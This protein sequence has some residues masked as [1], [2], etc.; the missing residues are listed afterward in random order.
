MPDQLRADIFLE[1]LAEA[2]KSG[3]WPDFVTII[4]PNDHTCGLNPGY[5]TPR[6]Y[7]SDN[8]LALGRI[9]EGISKS[10]FWPTTVIFV[11]EDDPQSGYDHV[12][13]HRSLCLVASPYAKHGA[14]VSRFYNQTS[15]LHTIELILGLPPMNQL[16]AA[17][18][19]MEDCFQATPDPSPYKCLVPEFPSD[20][21]NG[22]RAV[23]MWRRKDA[24]PVHR[25]LRLFQ[26]D[27]IDE[28]ALNRAAW[29][30]KRRASATRPSTRP[31]RQ[32][33]EAVG[34]H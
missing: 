25:R 1:E 4:L 16:D 8:D 24:W 14:V 30:R 31:A 23:K 28:D 3:R 27:L 22:S 12:D 7:V 29:L 32:K 5:P 17:A 20:Q 9:V 18:P 21:P 19:T 10:R 33:A 26:A 2:E 15:V 13:G 34:R 6:A 11:N